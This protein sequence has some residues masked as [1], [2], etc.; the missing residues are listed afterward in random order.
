M[1]IHLDTDIGGDMDDLCALA[2][3]LKWPDIEITGI[4]TVAEEQGRRAGYIR[5]VLNMMGRSGIPFAAGAD[6]ADGYFRYSKLGY[7]PDED[8]WPEPV[9]PCP[10]PA[11]DALALLKNSIDQGAVIVGI[12]PYTNFMLLDQ[13]HPGILSRANLTLVGGSIFESL[14][15]FPQW[16][17][18]DDWNIQLD[19]RAARHVLKHSNP[20]LVPLAMTSQTALRRSD[21]ARL[22][23]AG[24]FGKLLVQQA[25]VF[26]RDEGFEQKYAGAYPAVPTDIINFHHDPLGCAIAL[27]WSDGV[28]IETVP[29]QFEMRE[30]WLYETP[31]SGGI[32]TRVVT[33][34]DGSAFNDF[35]CDIIC[36]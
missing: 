18:S 7:P 28:E 12:G 9:L 34:I 2:M 15:G 13:L 8:N 6:L 5:Y 31:G 33:R 29:L 23:H 14:P 16:E 10:G 3:L 22:A 35:W 24:S 19:A 4:T 26:A 20:T 27:G 21:V 25:E 11:T 17:N 30:S 1:K 36:R 32:P